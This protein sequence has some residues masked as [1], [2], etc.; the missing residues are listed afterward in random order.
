MRR[1]SLYVRL[2]TVKSFIWYIGYT[3]FFPSEVS[4]TLLRDIDE[5]LSPELFLRLVRV[6]DLLPKMLVLLLAYSLLGMMQLCTSAVRS[7]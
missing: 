3:S 6:L 2:P 7:Q 1:V 5:G 4:I